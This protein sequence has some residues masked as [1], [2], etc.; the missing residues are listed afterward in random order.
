MGATWRLPLRER[1]KPIPLF[2]LLLSMPIL[3]P[4]TGRAVDFTAESCPLST[5]RYTAQLTNPHLTATLG[6]PVRLHFSLD[7][8]TPPPGFF[9]SINMSALQEPDAAKVKVPEILTG[10]PETRLVFHT[11]G[12]YR[13]RVVVSLIA[14]SS[15]GGVKAG[16]VYKGEAHIYARP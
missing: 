14:K 2:L 7:P 15:C 9:L 1:L 13:Y 11:P 5:H 10:F 4:A 3:M 6:E 12:V 16:T 8:P